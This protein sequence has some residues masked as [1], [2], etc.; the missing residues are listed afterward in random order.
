MVVCGGTHSSL[1]SSQAA[2][3][4]MKHTDFRLWAPQA[5]NL[6]YLSLYFCICK[7]GLKYSML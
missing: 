7:M 3:V 5:T 6:L 4:L 1:G 2:S